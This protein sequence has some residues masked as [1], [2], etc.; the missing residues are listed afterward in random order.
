M[1]D[2]KGRGTSV[3]LLICFLKYLINS[4]IYLVTFQCKF[5]QRVPTMPGFLGSLYSG[6][7]CLGILYNTC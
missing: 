3:L 4:F 1:T 6:G 7:F 2:K 5:Y